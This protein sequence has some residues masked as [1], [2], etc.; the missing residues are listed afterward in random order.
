M[1]HAEILTLPGDTVT[2]VT[3]EGQPGTPEARAQAYWSQDVE[4]LLAA[5]G[6]PPT[7]PGRHY[8]LWFVPANDPVSGGA[9]TPDETGRLATTVPRPPGADG[10]VPMAV[11]L[12]PDDLDAGPS[13][14]VVL[15]GRPQ[16]R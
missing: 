13:G 9:L 12:E 5:T 11:T 10:P 15:L 8:H 3:L 2:T 16:P 14:D 1:R 4:V 6:L 7:P